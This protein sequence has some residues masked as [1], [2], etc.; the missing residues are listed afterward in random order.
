MYVLEKSIIP[1]PKH[2]ENRS[3]SVE[4]ARIAQSRFTIEKCSDEPL[5]C[6]GAGLLLKDIYEKICAEVSD[7]GYKFTIK[8]DEND[9]AFEGIT[10]DEAYY[11][12]ATEDGAVLC[13]KSEK[14]N[15]CRF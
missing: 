7:T 6:E 9:P 2:I 11:I 8:V 13:G 4:I 12:D 5:T 14:K 10:S 3:S 15:E 1:M